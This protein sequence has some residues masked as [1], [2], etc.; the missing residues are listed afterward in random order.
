MLLYNHKNAF[1]STYVYVKEK[2]CTVSPIVTGQASP[3]HC[4]DKV[5]L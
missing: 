5:Q 3:N 4:L 1:S 2:A